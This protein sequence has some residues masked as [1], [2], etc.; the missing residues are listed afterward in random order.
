MW[1]ASLSHRISRDQGRDHIH[2]TALRDLWH[3]WPRTLLRAVSRHS[4]ADVRVV[5]WNV[6]GQLSRIGQI[7]TN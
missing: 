2:R 4:I 7:A 1:G 3:L 6:T 5:C